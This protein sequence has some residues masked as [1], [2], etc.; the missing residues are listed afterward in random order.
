MR[1]TKYQGGF[2]IA[3]IPHLLC[4]LMSTTYSTVTQL[5]KQCREK[6]G[7]ELNFTNKNLNVIQ[8]GGYWSFLQVGITEEKVLNY[9]TEDT[10]DRKKEMSCFVNEKLDI[11]SIPGEVQPF[12]DKLRPLF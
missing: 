2:S 12:A 11:I 1:D 10:R 9:N 7:A 3:L 8:E 4:L 5:H 6:E